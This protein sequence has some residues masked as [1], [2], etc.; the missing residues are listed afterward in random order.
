V[1]FSARIRSE[2]DEPVLRQTLQFLLDRHDILRTTYA[3]C[4]GVP[5]THLHPEMPVDFD[6]IRVDAERW[7]DHREQLLAEMRRPFD[8]ERGPILRTRL[9][10]RADDDYLLV[11]VIHHIAIDFWSLGVL[12]QE[13]RVVYAAWRAEQPVPLLPIWVTYDNFVRQQ[14]DMLA[15]P[16]GD[17]LRAYWLQH[18]SGE[19]PVLALPLDRP[20]PIVQTYQGA[21]HAFQLSRPLTEALHAM[22]R[23]E[24]ITLYM[25][26][27]AALQILLYRYSGQEDIW[28]GSP[29]A[30]RHRPSFRRLVGY[31]ANPVVMRANLSGNPTFRGF[32]SQVRRTVLD[33]LKHADYPF[34]LLVEHLQPQ[35]DA[36]RSPLFQVTL[37]LQALAQEPDLLPCFMPMPAGASPQP[38]DF[39]DLALEPYPLPHQEGLV[40][41]GFEMAEIASSICGYLKYNSDLFDLATIARMAQHFNTL[42]EGLAVRPD[43]PVDTLPLLTD[44]ERNQLLFAWNDTQTADL[45]GLCLHQLIEKQV[46]RTPDAVAVVCQEQSFTYADMNGKANQLAHHLQALGVGPEVMV[47]LCVASSPDMVVGLLG[48]LKA[49]GAYVALDP[50]YP[51]DRLVYMIEDTQVSLILTQ[52]ALVTGLPKSSLRLVCLDTDWDCMAQQPQDNPICRVALDHLAYVLYTSGSTGRPKG[53]LVTHR[54]FEN[55]A[56]AQRRACN[57]QPDSRI[58]Q[59]ASSNFDASIWECLMA[60]G[61]GAQLWLRAPGDLLAG[62]GF[63]HLLQRQGITHITLPPSVLATLPLGSCPALRTIMVA[64]E[65]CA[66][67]LAAM[68][69]YGRRFINAYG[70]TE[71]T[72]CATMGVYADDGRKLSMGRPLPNTQVYVLDSQGHPVPVGVAG[73]L[74][75]GGVGLARG[76]LNQPALTQERFVPNPFS[77]ALGARLYKTGDRVRYLPDGNLE[78]LGR[79]DRQ[80]KIRGFRIELSEIETVLWQN[81]VVKDVVVVAHEAPAGQQSLVAY[82][83][84]TGRDSPGS[85]DIDDRDAQPAALSR[86][87]SLRRFLQQKLPDYMVPGKFVILDAMP[88]TPNGKI[89]WQALPLPEVTR[90]ASADA[91]VLPQTPE[92]KRLQHIWCRVLGIEPISID[93]NFFELGGHSLQ[94]MQLVSLVAAELE[95]DIPVHALFV[96]PTVSALAQRLDTFPRTSSQAGHVVA[97]IMANKPPMQPSSTFTT[98]VRS[99]IF[100]RFS[101]GNLPPVHAA[102]L[103]YLPANLVNLTG[104]SRDSLLRDWCRQRPDVS[105]VLETTWGRIALIVLPLWSDDVYRDPDG[106]AAMALDAL[107]LAGEIGARTVSLT[108][109]LPSATDYGRVLANA[110]AGRPD[111]PQ[112]ST[113]HATTTSAMVLTIGKLLHEGGRHL[114]RERVGFLGLGSIGRS[115]L[116]LMLNVLPHPA[117]ILLCDVYAKHQTLETL[118]QNLRERTGF[119]G[120]IRILTADPNVPSA[121]YAATLI[122]GATNVPAILDVDRLRPGTMMVDDSAPHCFDPERAVQRI[123]QHHDLLFSEGGIIRSPHPFHELRYVPSAVEQTMTVRQF[124]TIFA[125]HDPHEIMG[126]TLSS[127]LSAR[128][129]QFPPTVGFVDAQASQQHYG[130]LKRLGAEAARLQCGDYV[131]ADHTRR[132]FRR[133]YRAS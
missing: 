57:V 3:E 42:L 59:F 43:E 15:R 69:S 61:A 71:Y 82:V 87:S 7:E 117:E 65:A 35:R 68:W 52:H 85:V 93:D 12:L 111:R 46:E 44:A 114:E 110:L 2:V 13:L 17:R 62:S 133:Q 55:L 96:Y 45:Q 51:H 98:F 89:N 27:L 56:A 103:A 113:G 1:V 33:A 90:T 20:R 47:G 100:P 34:S 118:A 108:G 5:T 22:A 8:L 9:Y 18:L 58:F 88:L 26:L 105:S 53:V 21:S 115:S 101:T 106:L 19:P 128:L 64:G 78:F 83:V 48:I 131:L 79:T 40:D 92:E 132:D 121:F 60:L 10:R 70:P 126:C 67:E 63:A 104:L 28:V 86:S 14:A 38:I 6:V 124:D 41:L 112:V 80:V 25:I 37:V 29:M 95:R 76:Y 72:V 120:R 39:G 122:V 127:L 50:T 24:G 30:C 49:G 125:R 11:L 91:L 54:G 73:E 31:C 130:M 74:H 99:A 109:L 116:Q 119:A 36:G 77:H 129:L 102:A 94:A 84:S 123:E 4:D 81:P 97:E 16:Q 107:A 75:I 66:A 23:R 32:L